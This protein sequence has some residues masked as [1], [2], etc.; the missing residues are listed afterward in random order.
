MHGAEE[1]AQLDRLWDEIGRKR[2]GWERRRREGEE[3]EGRWRNLGILQFE[4]YRF[5]SFC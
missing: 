2:V 5:I 4:I 3:W 1:R